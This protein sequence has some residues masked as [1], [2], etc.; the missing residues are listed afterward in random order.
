MIVPMLAVTPK[1]IIRS[2]A[3]VSSTSAQWSA[4][5]S[6]MLSVPPKLLTRP[7]TIVSDKFLYQSVTWMIMS[8]MLV[9]VAQI[10][11]SP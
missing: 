3:I 9:C 4:I 11:N 8:V 1:L 2:N 7:N 5:V 10:D 6:V